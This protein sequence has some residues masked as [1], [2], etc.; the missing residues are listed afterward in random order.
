M[1]NRKGKIPVKEY[2]MK[3]TVAEIAGR[4]EMMTLLSGAGRRL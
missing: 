4:A 3:E 2:L 1:E